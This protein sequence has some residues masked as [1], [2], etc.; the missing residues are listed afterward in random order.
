M[1]TLFAF[2]EDDALR[3]ARVT[4]ASLLSVF[5]MTCQH[6]ADREGACTVGATKQIIRGQNQQPSVRF[7]RRGRLRSE[8]GRF[9][10][11]VVRLGEAE[12]KCVAEPEG[13]NGGVC[14]A[15]R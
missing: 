15:A 4:C 3:P 14:W 13:G 6:G 9:G 5:V 11:I 12:P 2:P 10:Q 8:T 7:T 1:M